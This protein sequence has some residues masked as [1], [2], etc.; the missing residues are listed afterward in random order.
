MN[1]FKTC[2]INPHRFVYKCLRVIIEVGSLHCLQQR[3]IA[4]YLTARGE[5]EWRER[6]RE[7]GIMW[8]DEVKEYAQ[9]TVIVHTQ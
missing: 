2:W 1:A 6:G 9:L 5:G 7:E 3:A 4:V 8:M